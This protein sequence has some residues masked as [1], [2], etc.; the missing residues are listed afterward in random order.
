MTRL[1]TVRTTTT[2][3]LVKSLNYVTKDEDISQVFLRYRRTEVR[4]MD[5]TRYSG[6]FE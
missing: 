3:D 4:G 2:R 5:L 1:E 6:I